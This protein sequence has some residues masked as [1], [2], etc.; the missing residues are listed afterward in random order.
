MTQQKSERCI[1]AKAAGNRGPT[2]KKRRGVKATSVGEQTQQL[3]LR[4]GTAENGSQEPLE[5]VPNLRSARRNGTLRTE[6]DGQTSLSAL[7][8]GPKPKSREKQVVSTMMKEVSAQL[9]VA[10]LSVARNK[11]SAGPDRQSI[12]QVR[13]H[14]PSICR[15]LAVEL[16]SGEFQPG[17]IRRVWI[18]KASGGQRPLGIPN[19]VDR[20]VQEAVRRVLEP[21]YEPTFHNGSHGFR[22]QRSCHTAIKA[23]VEHLEEGYDWVVDIDLENYFGTVNH[24]RLM[25]RLAQRVQDKPLLVLIGKML[26][27]KVVMPDGIVE[28][29]EE[30]VPQG[31]PLSPLLSNIVLD[32]LDRELSRRGHR[33]VRYAD[34]CN[35]YVR[36]E[37]SGKRVM[38]SIRSFIEGR[39]RLK[40]NEKKSAVARPEERHFLGFRLRR[41]PLDGSVEVLLSA[42]SKERIDEKVRA[43][44][45]RNWGGSL[46]ACI[47]NINVYTL[48]WIGFFGICTIG[49]ER[50]LGN[51]DAHIRRRLRAIQLKQWK[52]KRT[53]VRKLVQMG[54][55]KHAAWRA[56]Y[57]GR[58]SLWALSHCTAVDLALRNGHWTER[59]LE[60]LV[61]LWTLSPHRIVVPEQQSLFPG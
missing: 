30:G 57:S 2:D 24:Q 1:V 52:R 12:E 51:L 38:G 49:V 58:K 37:R 8:A 34:D 27:A 25:D 13:E 45:P 16:Q 23:A 22:P 29:T 36:S 61:D 43:L 20:I 4:F 5:A 60:S 21:M 39:L 31:G 6:A 11:G 35:I 14:W 17:D 18:P 47:H 32:E 26:R 46:T 59:G 40:V 55:R 50:M 56:I 7:V 54:I 10:F 9:E 48:G 53:I 33:F 42:R 41:E 28:G 44:T 19:V 3:R 15:E